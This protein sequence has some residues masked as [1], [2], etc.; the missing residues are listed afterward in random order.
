MPTV[1]INIENGYNANTEKHTSTVK[2][3]FLSSH[4]S[5]LNLSVLIVEDSPYR[6]IRFEGEH[7]RT[8]FQLDGT[9]HVLT[10]GTFS[11]I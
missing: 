7:Q 2:V 9:G 5:K 6:E 8:M 3:D 11:K 4:Q 1:D 10:L